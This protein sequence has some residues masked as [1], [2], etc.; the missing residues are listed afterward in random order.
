MPR[1]PKLRE[2]KYELHDPPDGVRLREA[3]LT[4]SGLVLELEADGELVEAG[5]E[6]NLIVEAFVEMENPAQG[7][8]DQ[9]RT[10]RISLGV[11]P[12]IP[13]EIVRR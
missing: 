3:T 11:L 1:H 6:D 8:G 7:V 12:A 5:F 4:S 13:F 2:V 10:R 9:G